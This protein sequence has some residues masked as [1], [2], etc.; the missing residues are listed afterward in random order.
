MLPL[1]PHEMS[2]Q[3]I[4]W[5]F[6]SSDELKTINDQLYSTSEISPNSTTRHG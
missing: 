6:A 5:D 2:R 4:P 1:C 3:D